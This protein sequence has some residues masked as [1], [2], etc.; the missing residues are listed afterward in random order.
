MNPR[1]RK[2]SRRLWLAITLRS[3]SSTDAIVRTLLLMGPPAG[4]ALAL[5]LWVGLLSRRALAAGPA[6]RTPLALWDLLAAVGLVFLGL[7]MA[8]ALLVALG[9]IEPGA[10]GGERPAITQHT[11]PH[12]ATQPKAPEPATTRPASTPAGTTPTGEP[13]LFSRG[14]ALAMLLQTVA[15]MGLPTLYW[16]LRT[17]RP[18][19]GAGWL[20][21]GI[22]P[23][24]P[25]RELGVGLLA[26]LIA[27][28]VV[29]SA[30][31]LGSLLA[32]AV[33]DPAP[34]AVAHELLLQVQA[35]PDA[36]VLIVLAVTAILLVPVLEEMVYRGLVQSVL[37]QYL[38]RWRRWWVIVI[39]AGIFAPMH[40]M[41]VHWSVMPGLFALALILGYLYERTGSLLPPILVHVG[42][43]ALNIAYVLS[44]RGT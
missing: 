32:I 41:A 23:R 43:N 27:L 26:L 13:R 4:L 19:S 31:A 21:M 1:R 38:G 35:N 30:N 37:L 33:N 39:G 36:F 8:S 28:P 42:F 12:A 44:M 7:A 3:M 6:R 25:V 5:L 2:Q 15:M 18:L 16:L 20:A 24:R 22:V 29:V 14:E 40:A 17:S 11:A 10:A 34:S 9:L